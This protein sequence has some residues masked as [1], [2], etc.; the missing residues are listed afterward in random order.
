MKN[1]K[2]MRAGKKIQSGLTLIELMIVIAVIGLLAVFAIPAYSEYMNS[3]SISKVNSHYN[4]AVR[5]TKAVFSKNQAREAMSGN[6]GRPQ[7]QQ[8][9]L[10]LFNQSNV[11]APG[12]GLA[13]EASATGNAST[14]AIGIQSNLDGSEVTIVRPAYIDVT[15][16][17]ATLTV[18]SQVYVDL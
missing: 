7:N 17:S 15:A 9:W 14:G 11:V 8:G 2:L 6:S 4:E 16:V 3:A 1:K 13:F 12:G 5:L 18:G 10:D